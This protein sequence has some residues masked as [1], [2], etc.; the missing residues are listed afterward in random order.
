MH[1]LGRILIPP[2]VRGAQLQLHLA[3]AAAAA[4]VAAAVVVVAAAA[5]VFEVVGVDGKGVA[6]VAL[7]P[8]TA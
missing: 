8:A 1:E 7:V 2:D 4:A 5:F 3:A 6:A